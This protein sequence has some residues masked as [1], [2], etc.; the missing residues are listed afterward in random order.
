MILKMDCESCEFDSL[1]DTPDYILEKF[2]QI[3]I[4]FHFNN[5]SKYETYIKLL[6]KLIECFK[7]YIYITII[8]VI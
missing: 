6:K 5:K 8:I 2:E 3:V 1:L 7:V 4:E